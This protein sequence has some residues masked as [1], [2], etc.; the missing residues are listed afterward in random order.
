[1]RVRH[2]GA[3]LVTVMWLRLPARLIAVLLVV[4]SCDSA[5]TVIPSLSPSVRA[6]ADLSSATPTVRT[7]LE[8]PAYFV[9]LENE[10]VVDGDRPLLLGLDFNVP[11]RQADVED[12]LRATMPTG[13]TYESDRSGL[14]G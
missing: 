14:S 1:M 8:Y 11:M 10:L 4:V 3:R 12:R 5:P 7:W 13:T 2:L 9:Q 6:T